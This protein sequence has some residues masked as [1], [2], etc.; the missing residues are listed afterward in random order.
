MKGTNPIEASEAAERQRRFEDSLRRDT[1]NRERRRADKA[2]RALRRRQA[3]ARP[4]P[5]FE[6][7]EELKEAWYRWPLGAQCEVCRKRPADEAHHIVRQ[8]DLKR[9]ARDRGY[10]FE[11]VRWDVRNRLLVCRDC[12]EPHTNASRR[13]H[14]SCLPYAAF[15]FVEEHGFE[16]FLE[17]EYDHSEEAV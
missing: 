5:V 14:L 16:P 12:H 3:A 15:E 4:Q 8:K 13:I 11:E 9:L 2:K 7:Y 6:Q 10:N 1:A 17:R